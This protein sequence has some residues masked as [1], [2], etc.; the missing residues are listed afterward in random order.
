MKTV[1]KRR[2]VGVVVGVTPKEALRRAAVLQAQV[3]L[4]NPYPRPRGFVLKA[5]TWE[6]YTRWR[7]AQANPRLW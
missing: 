7:Q 2:P 1:G 3:D 4:L 6:D 5:R